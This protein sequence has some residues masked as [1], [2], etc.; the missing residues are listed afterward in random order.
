MNLYINRIICIYTIRLDIKLTRKKACAKGILIAMK[1]IQNP[2]ASNK[3][4]NPEP[5]INVFDR[6]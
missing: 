3:I 6:H 1:F 2:I 5:R 4:A